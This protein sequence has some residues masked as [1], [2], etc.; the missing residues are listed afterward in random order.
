MISEKRKKLILSIEKNV[1]Q[2]LLEDRQ[3]ILSIIVSRGVKTNQLYGEG[4]GTRIFYKVLSDDLLEEINNFILEST[5]KTYINLESSD[6]E[7]D[8]TEK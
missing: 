4:T 2:C 6:D 7:S 3:L 5:K 1:S 8:D